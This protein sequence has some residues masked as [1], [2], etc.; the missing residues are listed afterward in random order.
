MITN[1]ITSLQ[2]DCSFL[3]N[4]LLLSAKTQQ[5]GCLTVS[6]VPEVTSGSVKELLACSKGCLKGLQLPLVDEILCTE[7]WLNKA[8]SESWIC[9]QSPF[10]ESGENPSP[11]HPP[12]WF[13]SLLGTGDSSEQKFLAARSQ[14]MAQALLWCRACGCDYPGEEC[15]TLWDSWKS[16]N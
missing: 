16:H 7:T 12:S 13:C 9:E 8:E 10:E 3:Q 1:K 15:L 14:H 11:C 4:L 6:S 5:N 2:S